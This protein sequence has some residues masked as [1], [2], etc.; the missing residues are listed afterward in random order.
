MENVSLRNK[1][2]IAI[3]AAMTAAIVAFGLSALPTQAYA[4]YAAGTPASQVIA[5]VK[6]SKTKLIGKWKLI[7]YKNNSSKNSTLKLVKKRYPKWKHTIQF[8]KNGK[9]V[10]KISAIKSL[11]VKKT[12]Y[13]Y[14]WKAVSKTTCYLISGGRAIAKA[15]VSGKKITISWPNLTTKEKWVFKK[16]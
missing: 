10:E 13:K 14:S 3:I 1:A 16:M 2:A 12:V 9:S 4:D 5:K 7:K 8:K 6:P 15:K 11:G